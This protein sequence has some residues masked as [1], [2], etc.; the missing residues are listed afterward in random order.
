MQLKQHLVYLLLVIED[1][2]YVSSKFQEIFI[3]L[4]RH[5][6]VCFTKRKGCPSC[7][8]RNIENVQHHTHNIGNDQ[9]NAFLYVYIL[10]NYI[11]LANY[12][13]C[14]CV[15]PGVM[16][17]MTATMARLLKLLLLLM[18]LLLQLVVVVVVFMQVLF[19]DLSKSLSHY[20]P[21]YW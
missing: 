17:I 10:Y 8:T 6:L 13:V 11:L 9:V 1:Y 7:F 4:V 16:L 18:L 15:R 20:C 5:C 2:I 14:I 19:R 21:L 12:H 3:F